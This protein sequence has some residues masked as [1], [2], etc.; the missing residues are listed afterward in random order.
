MLMILPVVKGLG[1]VD[2]VTVMKQ[3]VG[4]V[5]SIKQALQSSIIFQS[6]ASVFVA[7]VVPDSYLVFILQCYT[8][9][10]WVPCATPVRLG[11]HAHA[12]L[13]NQFVLLIVV[14]ILYLICQWHLNVRLEPV[15]LTDLSRFEHL[16][17]TWLF[18]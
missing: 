2:F 7:A 14:I 9:Q 10:H 18:L 16:P 15:L 5:S 4:L 11:R 8:Q 13:L 17:F 1:L 12:L 6:L 3:L